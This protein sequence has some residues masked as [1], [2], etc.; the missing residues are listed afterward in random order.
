MKFVSN[1]NEVTECIFITCH[2]KIS[3]VGNN[4]DI[5]AIKNWDTIEEYILIRIKT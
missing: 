2:N 5:L 1:Y 4:N 3:G